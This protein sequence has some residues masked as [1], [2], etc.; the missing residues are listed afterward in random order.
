MDLQTLQSIRDATTGNPRLHQAVSVHIQ[1]VKASRKKPHVG[2]RTTSDETVFQTSFEVP[3]MNPAR[4]IVYVMRVPD[5]P[6]VAG[7]TRC[8]M[9][10]LVVTHN[11]PDE[12]EDLNLQKDSI[13]RTF[14][15]DKNKLANCIRHRTGA[16][17]KG[18]EFTQS[19]RN[20]HRY[21]CGSYALSKMPEVEELVIKM[22]VNCR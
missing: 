1:Q 22:L 9:K 8:G 6:H 14:D 3:P 13:D 10:L 20:P 12:Y 17:Y 18:L 5:M 7:G 19:Q 2:K 21:A 15:V 4:A 16:I 11:I